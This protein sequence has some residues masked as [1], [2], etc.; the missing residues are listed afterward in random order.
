MVIGT[1]NFPATLDDAD[2]L[3]RVANNVAATTTNEVGGAGANSTSGTTI[4]VASTTVAPAF[5]ASGTISIDSEII[6]YTAKTATTFTG[7]VRG[8]DGTTAAVH[9]AVGA[10][11]NHYETAL[12]H[13]VLANGLI[14]AETKL[15]TGASTPAANRALL[16]V[17]AG[18]SVWQAVMSRLFTFSGLGAD[19]ANGGAIAA[20]AWTPVASLTTTLTPTSAGST[21]FVSM[22]GSGGIIPTGTGANIASRLIVDGA[23]AYPIFA[24]VAAAN[25]YAQVL[26]PAMF[27]IGSLSVA[28]HSLVLQLWSGIAGTMYIRSNLVPNFEWLFVDVWEFIA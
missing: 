26:A 15:G 12:H 23:T 24:N 7:C 25:A 22:R 4:T 11:V 8:A 6:T 1:T 21:L 2:S 28:A 20:T 9:T 18:A 10:V 5:P 3:I 16:S 27:S 19:V 14:A 17:A 13:S